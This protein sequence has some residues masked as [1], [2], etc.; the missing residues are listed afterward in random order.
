[1]TDYYARIG[2]HSMMW[3]QSFT[4][5]IKIVDAARSQYLLW[6]LLYIAD[7]MTELHG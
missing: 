2:K 3:W 4:V 7:V 5:E 6:Q 1:M